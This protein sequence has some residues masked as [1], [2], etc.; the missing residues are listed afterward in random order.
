M[1]ARATETGLLPI[2]P[3]PTGLV[4]IGALV[5]F[6][7]FGFGRF[8]YGALLPSIRD[9]LG[10]SYTAAGALATLNLLAY[11]AGAQ[12]ARSLL[13]RHS[14]SHLL[15]IAVA[16]S[17]AAFASWAGMT[18]FLPAVAVMAALGVLS[19]VGWISLV[20]FT[21]EYVPPARQGRFLGLASLGSAWGIPA[22]A[23]LIG[24]VALI[25]NGGAWRWSWLTMAVISLGAALFIRPTLRQMPW[26]RSPR[27]DRVSFREAI[28][29]APTVR[30][31]CSYAFYGIWFSIFATF[32]VSFLADGGLSKGRSTIVWAV[33][34]AVAG[35]GTLVM[36]RLCDRHDPRS[37][38]ILGLVLAA[39]LAVVLA[40]ITADWARFGTVG[41][42]GF[43][44]VG[45]GTALTVHASRLFSDVSAS[46]RTVAAVTTANAFG[47]SVGPALAG[48]TIDATGSYR[49]A[50]VL[51]AGFSSVAALTLAWRR[52]VPTAPQQLTR[53]GS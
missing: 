39:L 14:S 26:D 51:A 35:I 30:L 23:V 43:P 3:L 38:A 36:G 46:T 37:V 40:V 50:F 19:A 18:S 32:V 1:T 48:P 42:I 17:A 7:N 45:T 8:A 22:V 16:G 53:G 15:V 12:A 49:S 25:A 27:A 2:A 5:M 10:L 29:D 41:L 21:R 28:S 20:Q 6:V 13:L 33:L 9:D 44:M 11:L 31:V 52:S 4:G 24:V 47:Q 34:G